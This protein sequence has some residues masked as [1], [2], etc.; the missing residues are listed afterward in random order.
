MPIETTPELTQKLDIS[1][2]LLV[3]ARILVVHVK[4]TDQRSELTA[5]TAK[6]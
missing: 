2:R 1:A 4:A 3:V 6:M 5:V